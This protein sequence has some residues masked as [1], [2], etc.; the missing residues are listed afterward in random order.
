MNT[1][2]MSVEEIQRMADE[3]NEICKVDELKEI[4]KSGDRVELI[5]KDDPFSMDN[6]Y[7]RLTQG[8]L[9]T[10][11]FVNALG[12]IDVSWDNGERFG[13][14]FGKDKFKI[15]RSAGDMTNEELLIDVF[16]VPSESDKVCRDLAGWKMDEEGK[17]WC[18]RFCGEIND[19]ESPDMTCYKEWLKMMRE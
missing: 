19:G 12:L 4:C 18:E 14:V 11:L 9:G 3:F 6:P 16:C 1:K 2:P 15:V 10:V 13:L 5:S 7:S 8:S 17:S